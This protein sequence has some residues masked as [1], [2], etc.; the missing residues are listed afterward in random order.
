ML[1]NWRMKIGIYGGTFNP[2]H[3]GHLAVAKAVLQC[4]NLDRVLLIVTNDPPHK[5]D[6]DRISG[7][8]RLEMVEEGLENEHKLFAS[9][10]EL[11]RGGVSYTV[12][13]LEHLCNEN[14]D[15]ELYFIVGA[16]M[17]ENFPSWYEPERILKC[18]SLVAV[19]RLN[20]E[21]DMHEQHVKMERIANSIEQRFGGRVFV[22]KEYGPDIS[23][24]Q[25]RRAVEN[26]CLI[27]ELVPIEVEKYIYTHLLYFDEKTRR[28]GER[29]KAR[30][31]EE[32][33]EHTMLVAREAVMLAH[34]YG[35][36]TKKAR[37]AGMLHD[38]MK[39]NHNDLIDYV[40]A[41]GYVLSQ[42]ELDYPF[43]IH[44]RM[45]AESAREEFGVCD[46]EILNAI[47]H[48]TIGSTNM[49]ALDK[50]VFIADKI[51]LSRNYKGVEEL[52]AIAYRDINSAVIAIMKNSAQFAIAKGSRVHPDTQKIIA[53]LECE[54][55][56]RN[57]KKE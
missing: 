15:S 45:G 53:A 18:A 7:E 54:K 25:I 17:L 27:S 43:T 37:L 56:M 6:A 3:N 13:T 10:I 14:K 41:H 35:V 12:E 33:F 48:H 32:R 28:I 20:G 4:L 31:D 51:E 49:S 21:G 39:V 29:L 50:I 8:V 11:K 26:A 1:Y 34:R 47:C 46:E 52:R 16:D 42:T 23:S 9:D 36:D 2:L 55:I 22:L 19:G 30:L 5:H 40:N 57:N 44:G 38:C 24:T